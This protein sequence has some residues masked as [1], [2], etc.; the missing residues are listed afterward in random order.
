MARTSNLIREGDNLLLGLTSARLSRGQL[1][2][3]GLQLNI[4]TLLSN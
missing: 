3:E 2:I 1:G 4:T